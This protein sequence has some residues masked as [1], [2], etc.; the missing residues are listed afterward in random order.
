M[1][2]P[3]PCRKCLMN[4]RTTWILHPSLK[5]VHLQG[6][7]R[8]CLQH[9]PLLPLEHQVEKVAPFL[10]FPLRLLLMLLLFHFL[11]FPLNGKVE[12]ISTILLLFHHSLCN[13]LT[14]MI[15][16]GW[17]WWWWMCWSWTMMK[18]PPLSSAGHWKPKDNNGSCVIHFSSSFHQLFAL[19][20]LGIALPCVKRETDQKNN[21]RKDK[22]NTL[23]KTLKVIILL[24]L[25]N[26]L[27]MQ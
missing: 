19:Q 9:L 12:Q 4:F 24:T 6:W 20:L 13:S 7:S 18:A 2:D 10:L 14:S 11:P 15:V 23:I 22:D 21:Q 26:A 1:S 17:W 25:N 27:S 3:P 8:P 16:L 5:G